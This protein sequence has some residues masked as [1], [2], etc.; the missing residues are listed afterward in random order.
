[1]VRFRYSIHLL[2]WSGSLIDESDNLGAY[3]AS[4]LFFE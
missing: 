3:S 1:M 4:D 2:D